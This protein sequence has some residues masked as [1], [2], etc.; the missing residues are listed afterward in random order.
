M[1][2]GKKKRKRQQS[3]WLLASELP[4]AP[5]HPFYARLNA[6][7]EGERFDEYVE[8]RCRVG[9]QREFES[10]RRPG[11]NVTRT[12]IPGSRLTPSGWG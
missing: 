2:M 12:A 4:T 5:G 6:I 8:S 11:W 10:I 1:A 7:L 3:M 9:R